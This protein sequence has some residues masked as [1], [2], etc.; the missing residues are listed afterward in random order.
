MTEHIAQMGPMLILAGLVTGW[1]AETLSRV[2]GYGFKSD[3]VVGL[4]GSVIGGT[5]VWVFVSTGAGMP[6]MFL[7]GCAAAVVAIVAQRG[8]HGRP[9][10]L[11]PRGS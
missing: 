7:I 4:I 3:M 5:V 2:G 9:P 11:S 10:R 6:G 1:M 8:A